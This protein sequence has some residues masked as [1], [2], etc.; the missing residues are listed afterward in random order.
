MS[1][2]FLYAH[3]H[4]KEKSTTILVILHKKQLISLVRK[5]LEF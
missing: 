5:S 4:P 2:I 3:G 1:A